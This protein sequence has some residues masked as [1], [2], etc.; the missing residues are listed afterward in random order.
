MKKTAII[1]ITILC[2]IFYSCEQEPLEEVSVEQIEGESEEYQ[3]KW[4][5]YCN[6]FRAEVYFTH[7]FR[8]LWYKYASITGTL[9]IDDCTNGN[10]TQIISLPVRHGKQV[11]FYSLGSEFQDS[12]RFRIRIIPNEDGDLPTYATRLYMGSA[13]GEVVHQGLSR[14]QG[15]SSIYNDVSFD[16]PDVCQ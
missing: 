3:A 11:T 15:S 6:S 7:Q 13:Y 5:E 4:F 2:T 16:F 9:I 8:H 12:D 10:C 14:I 1:F